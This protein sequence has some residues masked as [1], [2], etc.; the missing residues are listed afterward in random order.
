MR[1]ASAAQDPRSILFQEGLERANRL[2]IACEQAPGSSWHLL[3]WKIEKNKCIFSNPSTRLECV[4]WIAHTRNN[5]SQADAR[6]ML[7]VP[8][9]QTPAKSRSFVLNNMFIIP[10]YKVRTW[11]ADRVK[12]CKKK[13][14]SW[15]TVL[16]LQH[17]KN[18]CPAL[19]RSHLSPVH[20]LHGKKISQNISS[21]L[22]FSS[23]SGPLSSM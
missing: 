3:L 7:L 9:P 22:T 5:R 1:L 2:E 11:T 17:R 14:L 13:R 10:D 15:C 21:T 8:H 4:T 18:I 16:H 6:G 23:L 20:S 19:S 12:A